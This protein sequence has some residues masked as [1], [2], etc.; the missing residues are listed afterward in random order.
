MKP[1]LTISGAARAS[2]PRP[3]PGGGGGGGGAGA[4]GGGGG[5]GGAGGRLGG[6][7]FG[8]PGGKVG[9]VRTIHAVPPQ[10]SGRAVGFPLDRPGRTEVRAEFREPNPGRYPGLATRVPH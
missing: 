3:P 6:G 7:G 2:H 10:R 9:K 8:R 1:R 5:G 4:A